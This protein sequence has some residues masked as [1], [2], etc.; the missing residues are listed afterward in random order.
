MPRGR[1]SPSPVSQGPAS[2]MSENWFTWKW[3]DKSN[4]EENQSRTNNNKESSIDASDKTRPVVLAKPQP[5]VPGIGGYP[6]QEPFAPT[7]E[8][9]TNP[10]LIGGLGIG[11]LGLFYY[12]F[13]FRGR[14]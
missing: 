12:A 11:L 2:E 14:K 1:D 8:L 6:G 10:Y 3:L 13:R 9:R 7:Q 5:S 4:S